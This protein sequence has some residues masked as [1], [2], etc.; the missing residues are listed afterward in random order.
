MEE[1]NKVVEAEVAEAPKEEPKQEGGMTPNCK[2]ALM[3]FIFAVVGLAFSWGWFIG[4][5][6][7]LVLGI[8]SVVFLKKVEGEVEKQPF[9][10]FSKIAKPLGIVAIIL[11]ACGLLFWL[12][13]TIVIVA[14]AAAAA[15]AEAAA[16]VAVLF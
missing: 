7:G 6:A 1:E 15:A 16:S 14:L 12:I 9:R 8:L 3:A 10:T 4:S 2:N 5:V 13:Y 11:S